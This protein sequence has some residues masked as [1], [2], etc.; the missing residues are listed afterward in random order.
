MSEESKD[1]I[2]LDRR[3]DLSPRIAFIF[4]MM[5]RV[6][7]RLLRVAEGLM[8][9]EIDYSPD[10]ERIETIGTLLLH[11]AAVEWSW[12]FEDIDGFL[13]L[14]FSYRHQY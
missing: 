14:S 5:A 2:A 7:S 9:E 10:M 4:S 6:R 3:G 8:D 12:I 11:I 13:Y 1:L